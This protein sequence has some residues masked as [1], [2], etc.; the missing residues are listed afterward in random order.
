MDDLFMKLRLF[1]KSPSRNQYIQD[2]HM[3]IYL[4]KSVRRINNQFYAF[5]DIAN[6]EIIDSSKRGKGL[7]TLF[8]STFLSRYPAINIFVECIHNQHLTYK[9][10][11]FGFAETGTGIHDLHMFLL[12][13]KNTVTPSD[14]Y[15]LNKY[16]H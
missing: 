9:L 1:L 12:N 6:I 14:V 7:F 8:L 3:K 13:S 10:K 2:D 16:F 4:R 11:Q 5:I 15:S